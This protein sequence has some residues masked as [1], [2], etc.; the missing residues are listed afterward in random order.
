MRDLRPARRFGAPRVAID[1]RHRTA[2][3]PSR[4]VSSLRR[5]AMPEQAPPGE[6]V[7]PLAEEMLAVSKRKVE[8]GRVQVALTTETQTVIARETLRGRRVEVER[9]PVGRTLAEGDTLVIPVIEETAVVVK[10]L[11]IQEE[12]R[13]HFVP[14]ERLFEQAV[15]VRRQQAIVERA[16]PGTNPPKAQAERDRR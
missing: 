3:V 7:I 6:V 1:D 14:T 5:R 2:A 13:L 16:P 8:T 4:F 11:V 12:V 9:V 10:R 15:D